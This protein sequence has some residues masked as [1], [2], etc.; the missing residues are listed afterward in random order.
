MT[1]FAISGDDEAVRRQLAVPEV[2]A[3]QGQEAKEQLR[4]EGLPDKTLQA[5]LVP[6]RVSDQRREGPLRVSMRPWSQEPEIC[7]ELLAKHNA[8]TENAYREC[9]R[10]RRYK[11]RS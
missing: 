3:Q 11:K 10:G 1:M 4:N 8:V 5:R 6:R 9:Y 2:D 7:V